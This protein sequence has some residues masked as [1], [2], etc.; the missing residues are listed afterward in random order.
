MK[1]LSAL[2]L[3]AVLWLALLAGCATA[4]RH[5]RG[6]AASQSL[7]HSATVTPRM[8]SSPGASPAAPAGP[9]QTLVQPENPE[10]ESMQEMRETVTT[11]TPAGDVV[12]TVRTAR[13]VIGGSQSLSDI[14]KAYAA[15][16]YTR[17]LALALVLAVVAFAV[18]KDWPSL[19]WV[20]GGGAVL[21]A[22]CGLGWALAIL[23]AGGGVVLAYYLTTLKAGGLAVLPRS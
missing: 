11:T 6:G 14:M 9:A 20:F 18:R 8:P 10:G 23:G 21:V 16:E 17:R 4:P 15:S 3:L 13:T 7:G 5:Q 12:T 2:V 1:S 22:F 19:Q